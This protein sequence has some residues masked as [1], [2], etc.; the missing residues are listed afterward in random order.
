MKFLVVVT[1]PSMFQY[2]YIKEVDKYYMLSFHIN[3]RIV[4]Q[5]IYIIRHTIVSDEVNE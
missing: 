2:I 4:P 1:P 3:A 5:N